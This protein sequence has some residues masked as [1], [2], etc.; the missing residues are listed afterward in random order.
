MSRCR[1]R[2]QCVKETD[3]PAPKRESQGCFQVEDG[4]NGEH[5]GTGADEVSQVVG[6]RD[7]DE[8]LL[9]EEAVPKFCL[10]SAEIALQLVNREPRRKS[11][12]SFK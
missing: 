7:V 5:F 1:H 10:V 3:A 2:V 4:E 8:D 12:K 9:T 6:V 11:E